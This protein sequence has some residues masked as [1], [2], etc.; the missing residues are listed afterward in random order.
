ME[1]D[2]GIGFAQW[3]MALQQSE[4]DFPSAGIVVATRTD[5]ITPPLPGASRLRLL[6]VNRRER[7][8]YLERRLGERAR[9]L[10]AVLDGDPVL[11]ELTRTPLILSEV[12]A[13]FE[14]GEATP[15]A[16]MGVLEGA[17]KLHERSEEHASHLTLAPLGGRAEKY[18]SALARTMTE[19][20]AVT[21]AEGDARTIASGVAIKLREDGQIADL[22]EQAAIINTLCAHHVLE[23]W[24]THRDGTIRASAVSGILRRVDVESPTSGTRRRRRR[25]RNSGVHKALRQ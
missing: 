12:T 2:C 7:A 24:R 9:E 6:P 20:G 25:T 3:C 1:R 5:Q 10:L 15:K 16:K 13:L 23:G 19:R 22:P 14:A 18:L 4:R 8:D 21:M 11:D 17:V